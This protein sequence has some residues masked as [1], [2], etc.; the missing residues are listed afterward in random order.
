MSVA[1][2]AKE[3]VMINQSVTQVAI[4][5]ADAALS[6]KTLATAPDAVK[7]A[8]RVRV[9]NGMLRFSTPD[10]VKDAGRVRVGNGMLRF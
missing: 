2:N 7:D 9:G 10:A 8:G 5:Q 1:T 3:I 4:S 6:T